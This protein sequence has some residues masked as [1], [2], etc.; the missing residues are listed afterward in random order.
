MGRGRDRLR[1][2]D[3]VVLCAQSN[4]KPGAELQFSENSNIIRY[5]AI[6]ESIFSAPKFELRH[7]IKGTRNQSSSVV[8]A[9]LRSTCEGCSLVVR[10]SSLPSSGSC[11][12]QFPAK[13]PPSHDAE[14]ITTP[15]QVPPNPSSFRRGK[16]SLRFPRFAC[17]RSG[18]FGQSHRTSARFLTRDGE[19]D[20]FVLKGKHPI[21]SLLLPK[22]TFHQANILV[23]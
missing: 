2:R 9:Q 17:D 23:S 20:G 8:V 10:Y 18:G 11:G 6:L 3:N 14:L 22:T 7:E 1:S 15:G 5:N 13:S 16:G 21:P 19:Q 12:L 4:S